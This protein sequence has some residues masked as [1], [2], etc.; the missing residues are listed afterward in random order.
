MTTIITTYQDFL[1]R[2][3]SL[4]LMSLS[5]I[6]PGLPLLGGETPES[7]GRPRKPGRQSWRRRRLAKKF[8]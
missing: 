3:E 5:T 7:L 4:G 8:K 6:L 2:L 1:T